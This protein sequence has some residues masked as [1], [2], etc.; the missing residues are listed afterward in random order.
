MRVIISPKRGKISP[1]RVII[2][3]KR[4]KLT[5]WDK[6]KTGEKGKTAGMGKRAKTA[7]KG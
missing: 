7:E 3:P 6:G 5:R 2:S 1:K 4:G